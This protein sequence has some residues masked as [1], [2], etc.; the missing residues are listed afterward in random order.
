VVR[1]RYVDLREEV[2]RRFTVMVTERIIGRWLRGLELTRLQPRPFRPKKDAEAQETFK[3]F[4]DLVK[5]ALLASATAVGKPIEIWFGGE[6]RAGQKGAHAYVWAPIASRL[7]MVR[8]V[9]HDSVHLFGAICPA[10]SV[11]P[12][13]SCPRSTP[14]R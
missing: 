8:D 13:L 5:N 2:A 7:A 4:S 12:P 3:K 9:R 6:A 1:W 11:G 14:R 10:C